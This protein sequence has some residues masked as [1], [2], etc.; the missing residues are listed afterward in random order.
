MSACIPL[1]FNLKKVHF[2]IKAV[3]RKQNDIVLW[4]Y[5]QNIYVEIG[6]KM[7]CAVPSERH[8]TL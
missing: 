6:S 4:K 7:S 1:F 8:R 3:Y 5:L 2:E